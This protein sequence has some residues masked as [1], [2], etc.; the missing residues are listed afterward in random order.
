MHAEHRLIVQGALNAMDEVDWVLRTDCPVAPELFKGARIV[1]TPTIQST[2][3]NRGTLGAL[4]RQYWQ[5][6]FWKVR[7]IPAPMQA[8]DHV[9]IP[10]SMTSRAPKRSTSQPMTGYIEA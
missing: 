1:L 3:Y 10:K 7:V 8:D 9:R 6:G 5:Y 2:Y 4:W